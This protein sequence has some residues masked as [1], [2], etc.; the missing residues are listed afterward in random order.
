MIAQIH[1]TPNMRKITRNVIPLSYTS[2][3]LL[4]VISILSTTAAAQSVDIVPYGEAQNSLS[5]S[6]G[7]VYLDTTYEVVGGG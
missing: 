6:V 4:L 7:D 3:L 2:L 1:T 5:G